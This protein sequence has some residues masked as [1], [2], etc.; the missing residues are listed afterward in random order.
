MV[1]K[2]VFKGDKKNAK[3]K[4]AQLH[5]HNNVLIKSKQK[6]IT[7]KS[8]PINGQSIKLDEI[9]IERLT[10]GWTTLLPVDL[11]LA[12]SSLTNED[13][14]KLPII[15]TYHNSDE[16]LCL[17]DEK[18]TSTTDANI[19]SRL[20]FTKEFELSKPENTV[21][22]T[23][24]NI[25]I[26]S[27]IN[28]IEPTDVSEVFILSD[29][30]SLFQNSN[31]FLEGESG[32]RSK[33]VIYSIKSADGK[34]LICDPSTNEL[35][36]SMTLTENGLFSFEF[37]TIDMIPHVRIYIGEK[38]EYRTLIVGKNGAV[39]I[40]PDPDDLLKPMSR[41]VLRIKKD[42]S[43]TTKDILKNIQDKNSSLNEKDSSDGIN[44]IVKKTVLELSKLGFKIT[45]KT[46]REIS[47][48]YDEG[49][50]NQW[51]VEFKERNIS[52][53]MA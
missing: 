2:L 21:I 37:E 35:K 13:S 11:Q 5:N 50:I 15:I 19:N 43:F 34:F 28:R 17:K 30:T 7:N 29:V 20:K 51:V 44:G 49:N 32:S 9:N 1:S 22:Y 27:V 33:N 24:E 31:K 16:H 4:K 23:T 10:N 12:K 42:D 3:K 45:D 40:I 48:A 25:S 38:N 39:K 47:R 46:L 53:R 26:E 14:G 52:D 8:F 36:M 6:N 18:Y 41:F